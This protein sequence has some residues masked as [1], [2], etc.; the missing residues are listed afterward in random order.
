MADETTTETDLTASG[1]EDTTTTNTTGE[2][3]A[4][5]FADWDALVKAHPEVEGLYEGKTTG[6]KSALDK[7]RDKASDAAKELRK[8]AKEADEKTAAA[9]TKLA[10]EKDA[11]VASARQES[12]FYREAAAAG[13]SG[14]K[15]ARAWLI[16]R[17]GDFFT[18][19][20]DPDISALKDELPELFAQPAI[21]APRVN[22]GQGTQQSTAATHSFDDIVRQRVRGGT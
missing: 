2:T 7:E 14:D 12:A 21:P 15:L 22:A 17:N 16:C 3:P 5:A 10:D 18:K 1:T 4:E 11:E 8:L 6:L 9:L 20:G 13:V 19:R